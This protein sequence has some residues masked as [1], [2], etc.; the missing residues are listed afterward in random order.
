MWWLQVGTGKSLPMQ[1]L[2]WLLF[3]LQVGGLCSVMYES[4]RKSTVWS[5][6]HV[7][8]LFFFKLFDSCW[9]LRSG[10]WLR[11][12]RQEQDTGAGG[13][14]PNEGWSEEV[15]RTIRSCLFFDQI[16]GISKVQIAHTLPKMGLGVP[17]GSLPIWGCSVGWSNILLCT[18]S[19]YI[20]RFDQTRHEP[21]TLPAFA[22]T[23]SEADYQALLSIQY[24]HVYAV[25]SEKKRHW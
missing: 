11:G 21:H 20:I 18:I 3:G 9:A 16:I 10:G 19:S 4:S 22:I 17:C 23:W 6:Q 8:F 5:K 7:G 2:R 15:N 12:G 24:M 1:W 25:F 13:W 14:I